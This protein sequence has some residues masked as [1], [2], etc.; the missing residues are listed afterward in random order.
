[1]NLKLV[2]LI[3]LVCFASATSASE[4]S[5][6]LSMISADDG[7]VGKYAKADVTVADKKNT[8]VNTGRLLQAVAETNT[9]TDLLKS[10]FALSDST[11]DA[12]KKCNVSS[13]KAMERCESKNGSGNCEVVAPGLVS[14]KCPAGN[15]IVRLGHSICT[16]RCPSGFTDRGLDCYKPKGY[17]T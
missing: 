15:D 1:M 10:Y 4:V 8:K 16:T 11:Q 3:G 12:I 6:C 14:K 5:K 7:H 2:L 9:L 13:T 17:K